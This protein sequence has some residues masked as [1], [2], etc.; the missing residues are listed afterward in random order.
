MYDKLRLVLQ[1]E[2]RY[3]EAIPYA[4]LADIYSDRINSRVY[5]YLASNWLGKE[6]PAERDLLEVKASGGEI[7]D[8]M[9]EGAE[10]FE[11][12]E[13]NNLRELFEDSPEEP[14]LSS[15]SVLLKKIRKSTLLPQIQ[16]YAKELLGDFEKMDSEVIMEVKKLIDHD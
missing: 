7:Q 12:N 1:R 13:F 2:Q 15:V 11:W 8:Y 16:I 6:R 3:E 5:E 10:I 9:A 14:K 4:L